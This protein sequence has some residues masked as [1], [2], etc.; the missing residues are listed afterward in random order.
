[1]T[2]APPNGARS[3]S[4]PRSCATWASPLSGC[5]PIIRALMSGFPALAS[6]SRR[7]SR[8]TGK[9]DAS[10]SSLN[11]PINGPL[12]IVATPQT[13]ARGDGDWRDL[14]EHAFADEHD[15]IGQLLR[16]LEPSAKIDVANDVGV[17]HGIAPSAAG[18]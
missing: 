3:A 7:S 4:A 8:S 11:I 10:L 2:R 17:A 5:A 9:R 1:M 12:A 13:R 14:A 15:L 18:R 16:L 6:R